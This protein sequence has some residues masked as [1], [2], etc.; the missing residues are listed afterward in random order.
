MKRFK[1]LLVAALFCIALSVGATAQAES[2][3]VYVKMQTS[4][5]NIVLELDRAKAPKTVANF[6]KYVN[7]GHY[8]GTI[9]HRVIS[10]FMIQGGNMDKHMN[11]KDTYAPIENEARN[12]LYNDK[13]TISMARTGNPHSAT[14]QFFINTADN[15]ALNFKSATS[16]GWG[17]AVFGKVLGGKKVVDKIEKVVTF[18][19]GR[20]DD[21]PVKPVMIIKADEVKQ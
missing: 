7:E 21:V 20:Y 11:S 4:K 12:G 1:I 5:G 3:K 13:Y 2:S 15:G 16:S 10:G 8:D 9:F 19:K 6:L 17:Y 14:D 18:R